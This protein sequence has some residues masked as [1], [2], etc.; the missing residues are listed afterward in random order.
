MGTEDALLRLPE[1][2]Q[3]IYDKCLRARC[4]FP[5]TILSYW[6]VL[7]KVR[8]KVAVSM[9]TICSQMHVV[10]L[11]EFGVVYRASLYGLKKSST[12]AELV[13]VKTLK[14]GVNHYTFIYIFLLK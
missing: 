11:G 7:A 5:E 4:C 3:H 9:N 8:R 1:C 10:Y 14:G 13:A 12:V 6:Q 2:H